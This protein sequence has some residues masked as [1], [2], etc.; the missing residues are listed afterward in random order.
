MN[1]RVL[2]LCLLFTGYYCRAQIDHPRAS[3]LA[4]VDQQVGLSRV[5]VVY[6]RP[7]VRNR[8]IFGGLVPY[9]RIWRVGANESTKFSID[10]QMKANGEPLAAGTYAL[11]AFPGPDSW[12]IVFHRDTTHWGDGREAYDPR[13]DALRLVV[14]PEKLPCKQE[15]F[16]I[17]FDHIDHN[18]L[19]MLWS[20]D[21]TRIRVAL[22]V[23]TDQ[24]MRGEIARKLEV[25]PTA[26][27]YYEA[28]RYFQEQRTD[29]G[30]ALQ[31]VRKAIAMAGDTYYFYRIKSLIEAALGDLQFCQAV[32]NP[33]RR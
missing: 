12:E 18:G 22:E 11:Y 29:H 1:S 9:G 28:A 30:L 13:A 17:S 3:P 27:T 19:E 15:N 21:D 26:Q 2:I 4:R 8:R 7:A 5:S 31:Y 32:R 23:N 33:G 10:T 24:K 6:S 14:R 16:L 25:S 20:W